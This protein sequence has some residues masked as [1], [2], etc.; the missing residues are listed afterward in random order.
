MT[1][2][3]EAIKPC[4]HCNGPARIMN[5]RIRNADG[6]EKWRF[7][8]ECAA[9]CCNADTEAEAADRWNRRAAAGEG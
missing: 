3:T 9:R 6:F 1:D 2:R 7:D 5:V 4:P 8:P